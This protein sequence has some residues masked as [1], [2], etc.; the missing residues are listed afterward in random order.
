MQRQNPERSKF[1]GRAWQGRNPSS[2]QTE[3][4]KFAEWDQLLRRLGFNDS[5]ALEAVKSDGEAAQQL[6][7]FVSRSL[8]QYFVPEAVITAVRRTHV[9]PYRIGAV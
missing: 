4:P 7:E 1:L 3:V 9:G 2:L 5:Q 8:R 6:R